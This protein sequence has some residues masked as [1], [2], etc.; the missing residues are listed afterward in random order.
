V[1]DALAK[2]LGRSAL[3][4]SAQPVPWDY[5]LWH[6]GIRM[7]VP[8]WVFEG[9]P[10]DQPPLAWIIRCTEFARMEASVSKRKAT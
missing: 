1:R 4:G 6:L 8:A 7:G 5:A 9:Y 3:D 2:A 10:A